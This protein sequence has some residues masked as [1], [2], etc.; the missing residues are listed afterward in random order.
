MREAIIEAKRK[1]GKEAAELIAKGLNI[2]KWDG[3]K[4]CCPVHKEDTPSF[5]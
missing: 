2:E 4:G 1:L 5:I 3:K